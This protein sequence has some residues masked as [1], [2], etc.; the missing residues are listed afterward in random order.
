MSHEN[1][2][3]KNH[4]DEISKAMSRNIGYIN[5]SE[6]MPYFTPAMVLYT[7]YCTL[8]LPYAD[9]GIGL[10]VWGSVCKTYL[11]KLSKLQK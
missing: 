6:N 9:Y 7:L 2:T 10:L 1:L 4:F 8:V 11:E 3:W 5:L